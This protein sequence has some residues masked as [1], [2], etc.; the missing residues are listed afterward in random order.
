MRD[1]PREL[2]VPEAFRSL[3]YSD[4]GARLGTPGRSL[5]APRTLRQL[6]QVVVI[7]PTSS[8]L[9]VGCGAG[10]SA[11][12]AAHLAAEVVALECDETL[13]AEARKLLVG[14]QRRQR[15][16]RDRRS[17]GWLGAGSLYDAIIVEGA[18]TAAPAALLPQLKDGGRL[19][20]IPKRGPVW[21]GRRLDEASCRRSAPLTSSMRRAIS[22]LASKLCRNSHSEP[23]VSPKPLVYGGISPGCVEIRTRFCTSIAQKPLRRLLRIVHLYYIGCSGACESNI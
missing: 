15:E 9:I 12:V 22:C 6:L 23:K 19:V 7:D 16:G 4:G 17:A 3:A 21:Q 2:F 18:L 20:A 10:Y 11:V 14:D 13:A 8:V 1:V 5:M